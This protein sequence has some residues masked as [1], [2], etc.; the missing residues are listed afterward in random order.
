MSFSPQLVALDIDG[1]LVDFQGR[2]PDAVRDAVR[3]VVSAGVPVVLST[4]RSWIGTDE[5][6]QQLGLPPGWAVCSNGAMVLS[7]PSVVIHHDVRFDPRPCVEK[8]MRMRPNA[9]LAVERG[10]ER[11]CTKPFPEGE[12]SGTVHVVDYEELV[13]GPVSRLIIREPEAADEEGLFDSLLAE[14][15]VHEVSYFVGWS[16]WLDIAPVGV[17]KSYGLAYVCAQLGVDRGDVLAIG[18]GRNDIEM[19]EWAG[20]GVAMGDA[21]ADVRVV[22]D[23]VT[24]RFDELG[25]VEELRRWF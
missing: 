15:G 16:A 10:L 5:I 7:Y 3:D 1:T 22:A 8:V 18:D 24:G 12:L 6:A 17:D 19:F 14:L 13:S 21:A 4:G 20:R 23:H 2:M 9:R 11:Y 25:A